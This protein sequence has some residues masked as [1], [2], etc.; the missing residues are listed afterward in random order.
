MD[1][2]AQPLA[3]EGACSIES[4]RE[5]EATFHSLRALICDLLRENHEFR[6]ALNT[7]RSE[8]TKDSTDLHSV[9]PGD[10]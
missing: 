3:S 2:S 1:C 7:E 4:N 6:M 5:T 8:T 10:R 9:A